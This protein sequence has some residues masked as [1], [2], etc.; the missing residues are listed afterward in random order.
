MISSVSSIKKEQSRIEK[1]G[2]ESVPT[3]LRKTTWFEYFVIQLAFSVNSGNFLVPA[4]AVIQGQLTFFAAFI[5]TVLGAS[6]AFLFVSYLSLPGAKN[7]I[8]A[9]Y[10][11]RTILGIRIARFMGSPIRT[12]TSLYWFA[13]QTIGGTYVLLQLLKIHFD[14]QLRFAYVSISLAI[15]MAVLALI[16]FDAVKKATKLFLPV[17]IVGQII[18]V[19][20]LVTYMQKHAGTATTILNTGNWEIKTMLFYASL[21]FVQYISGVSASSDMTRYAKSY[22]HG[23]WGLYS[24]NVAGF[25]ITALLGTYTAALSQEWNP[26]ITTSNMTSSPI[27][28]GIIF[29]CAMVSML[30]INLSNAYTGG[31]SLLNSVPA[32]GRIKSAIV[33]GLF[34][35]ILSAFP[36]LVEEAKQFISVLGAF[37]IPLSAVIITDF[38]VFKKST[39]SIEE[40]AKLLDN[41]YSYNLAALF[42]MTIGFCLYF[43]IPEYWS[44]GFI[45]F[46]LT[47]FFYFSYRKIK[48]NKESFKNA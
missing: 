33:F 36:T 14:I 25:I 26:F 34:A 19:Y 32:L 8:P 11:L 23:F 24:G 2:L 30:S 46:I 44:P 43:L 13:V 42:S 41:T 15:I 6:C 45:T 48:I 16:G 20:L 28:I 10:A 38:I 18:M 29:S 12:I 39:I 1:F 22:K 35:I 21:A 7:G 9:Q 5:S 40:L 3:E 31:F 27:L 17:L 47:S 4:L 37:I